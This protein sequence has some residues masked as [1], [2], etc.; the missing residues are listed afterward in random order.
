MPPVVEI[1]GPNIPTIAKTTATIVAILS[2]RFITLTNINFL[3]SLSS[4]KA[5]SSF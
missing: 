5:G 1:T 4:F 2:K 3:T